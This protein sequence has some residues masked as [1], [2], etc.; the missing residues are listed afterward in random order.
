M[1]ADA[2]RRR[3]HPEGVVSYAMGGMVDCSAAIGG[4][5][6]LD[7]I[8]AV[9]SEVVT[10]DGTG[11]QLR[12]G[13][14]AGDGLARCE[15]LFREVRRRFPQIWIE[16]LPAAEIM[17]LAKGSG[18]ESRETIAR[19]QDAGMDSIAGGGVDLVHGA[20]EWLAVHRTAHALGM[21]TAAVMT[22]G[23]GETAEQRV[24]FLEAV[25]ALQA[26]T[27]GFSAFVPEVADAPG[28]RELDGVTAVE[29][30]KTLAIAPICLWTTSRRCRWIARGR[31]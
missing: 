23:A 30:L 5:A 14:V 7:A 3:L 24:D 19:L 11:V 8:F 10:C 31:G 20:Q 22:F 1:E 2:V 12:C 26:E 29:R 18:L 21:Q 13:I 16:G 28:G 6:G 25:R 4:D 17:T 27:G 15:T 9:I